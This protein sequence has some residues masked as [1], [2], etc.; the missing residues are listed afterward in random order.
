MLLP[1]LIHALLLDQVILLR[2]ELEDGLGGTTSCDKRIAIGQCDCSCIVEELIVGLVDCLDRP[3]LVMKVKHD[4]LVR[5]SEE[6]Q[7]LI[8]HFDRSV[9]HVR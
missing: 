5:V 1:H 6:A 8:G 2:Q 3:A 4:D 7:F 9:V